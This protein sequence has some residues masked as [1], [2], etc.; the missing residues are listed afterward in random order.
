MNR[1]LVFAA[2]LAAALSACMDE[3]AG[4]DMSDTQ[5][6]NDAAKSSA[7]AAADSVAPAGDATAAA[8]KD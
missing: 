4:M 6:S 7:D 2:V 3:H 1:K 8:A 5:K